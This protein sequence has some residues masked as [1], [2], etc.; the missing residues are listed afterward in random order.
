M[1]RQSGQVLIVGV[2]MM[3]M[4]L[5]GILFL[6]DI[7]N[8]IR[9]KIKVST[10]QQAAA[11]TG[12][13][14]QKESLNLIGEINLIKACE[15][16]LYDDGKWQDG[17][18]TD[19]QKVSAVVIYNVLKSRADLL[20]EMQTRVS[21]TGPLV[22]FAAAN[23][24]A[25]ANGIN[26]HPEYNLDHYLNMV[27]SDPRY[28][29]GAPI[30]NYNWKDNYIW[31]ISDIIQNGVAI[32]PN[33]RM[34]GLPHV[35]PS[36]LAL[37]ALYDEIWRH[38]NE[39]AAGDPPTQTPWRGKLYRFVKNWTDSD[40]DG[41]WW[42]I[43]YTYSGF[44]KESEIFTLGVK[45]D[46]HPVDYRSNDYYNHS[47][48]YLVDM[49]PQQTVWA[50]ENVFDNL[51]WCVYDELWFPEYFRDTYSDY[52]ENHY[53]YWFYGDVLR[54]PFKSEYIYEG[55]CAYVE[56]YVNMDIVSRYGVGKN[57]KNY[58]PNQ[59]IRIGSRRSAVSS[60][61]DT[62][63]DDYRPGVAAKAFGK[64]EDNK[65]PI[66]I[67]LILPVFSEV[68]A[69]PTY[70]PEP[71][72]LSVMRFNLTKLDV[73]L[74]WLS[75]QNTLD[76]VPP[77]WVDSNYYYALKKLCD[78]KGFRYYG[79]NP[80]F[81]VAKFDNANQGNAQSFFTDKTYHY[82]QSN[83]YG[84]GWL[85]QVQIFTL[86]DARVGAGLSQKTRDYIHGGMATRFYNTS[87]GTLYVVLDS[88]N[89]FVTNDESDPTIYYNVS[90]GGGGGGWGTGGSGGGST[91]SGRGP[92]RF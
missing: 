30:N 62:N 6:F 13:K 73:F 78:G 41:K 55:P 91:D 36:E 46:N 32:S 19:P 33:S 53:Q 28:Y 57:V 63:I 37:Q 61:G 38:A 15:S 12:A 54:R 4:V 43:D 77:A 45:Y 7:H 86:R 2:I 14:W 5:L 72:N 42:D 69:V 51:R 3:V 23:Q 16:L 68:A 80:D 52:D 76:E 47:R 10:A 34:A 81:D 74:R 85:Q 90:G 27:N 84:P 26:G 35:D 17:K 22:G 21:F 65:P 29:N 9:S 83:P 40:F 88:Q 66:E 48:P 8:V 20:T 50:E 58:N 89:H 39:I 70:M 87:T 67:P 59:D 79:Y 18:S 71:Y 1:K 82:Q 31:L 64:L 24:A 75:Q 60:G 92:G 44:P 11:L 56:S 49:M 25:K